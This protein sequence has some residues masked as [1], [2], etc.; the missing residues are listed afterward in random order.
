MQ[1]RDIRNRNFTGKFDAERGQD[2]DAKIHLVKSTG[3]RLAR[4]PYFLPHETVGQVGKRRRRATPGAIVR[5]VVTEANFG[6]DL[7]GRLPSLIWCQHRDS[8]KRNAFLGNAPPPAMRT[9][10]HD[11]TARALGRHATAEPGEAV[12]VGDVNSLADRQRIDDFLA[13]SAC[14]HGTTSAPQ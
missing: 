2:V 9:I 3:A 1:F 5:D 10:F 7:R 8:A 6:Q 13:Q 11:P 12:V 14:R 4:W